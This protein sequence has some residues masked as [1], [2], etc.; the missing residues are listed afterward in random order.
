[1]DIGYRHSNERGIVNFFKATN[2]HRCQLDYSTVLTS[3]KD[4]LM[5]KVDCIVHTC[6]RDV[7]LSSVTWQLTRGAGR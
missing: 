4:N 6:L 3:C 1:M 7:A 5:L 2:A